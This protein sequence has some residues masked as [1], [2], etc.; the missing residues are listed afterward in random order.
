MRSAAGGPARRCSRLPTGSPL[1]AARSRDPDDDAVLAL[2]I[3]ARVDLIVS[4]DD[5]LLTL[6][7]HAGIPIVTTAEALAML[8]APPSTAD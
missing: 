4:G 7:S 8:R 2:A 6:A 1:P 5:D 3:A